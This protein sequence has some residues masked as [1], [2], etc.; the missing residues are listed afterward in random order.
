[1]RRVTI[2]KLHEETGRLV[3]AAQAGEVI[4]I[5]RRGVPVAELSG[6]KPRRR[7]VKLPDFNRRYAKFPHVESDSG[8]ML[9]EERR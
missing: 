6:F 3:D 9:E 8:K 7:K 4:L 5:Q 1:M 2:R